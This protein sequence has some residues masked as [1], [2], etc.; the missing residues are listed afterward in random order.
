MFFVSIHS[1]NLFFID[2]VIF[3]IKITF[4]ICPQTW[5]NQLEQNPLPV[6]NFSL[7]IH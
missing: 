4:L 3:I 1:S 6:S 5:Q 2:Y 7:Q